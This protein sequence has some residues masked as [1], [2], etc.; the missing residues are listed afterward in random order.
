LKPHGPIFSILKD[1]KI[2]LFTGDEKGKILL[3][4]SCSILLNSSGVRTVPENLPLKCPLPHVIIV[5]IN[6]RCFFAIAL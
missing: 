5:D 1:E 4:Y 3:S 2:F 6:D